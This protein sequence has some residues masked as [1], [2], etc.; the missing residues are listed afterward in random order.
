MGTEEG[1][2]LSKKEIEELLSPYK[3]SHL[4][5]E[6]ADLIVSPPEGISLSAKCSLPPKK[7]GYLEK[8]IDYVTATE[9]LALV[10]RCF[11]LMFTVAL[12][13]HL[14][15]DLRS[16]NRDICKDPE[17]FTLS[18]EVNCSKR[19]QRNGSSKIGK[20]SRPILVKVWLEE[21]WSVERRRGRSAFR[22]RV[23]FLIEEGRWD[24]SVETFIWLE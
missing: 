18:V 17:V 15:P 8:E 10:T 14:L 6:S 2:S 16:A 7:P 12:S 9:G 1:V 3:K 11:I 24:G 19:V 22:G 5:L 21:G 13:R 20:A 23:K 4:F